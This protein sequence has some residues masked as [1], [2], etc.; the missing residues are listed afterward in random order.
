[1]VGKEFN[2]REIDGL[3]AATPPLEALRLLVSWAATISRDGVGVPVGTRR[4]GSTKSILIAD[5]SRE[6]F[7]APAN[8]DLC[9]GLP[10]EA[11]KDGETP[12]DVV[13]ELMASLYGARDASADWQEEM[14]R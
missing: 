3:F 12:E 6:F 7:E 2:D 1:M 10:A 9:V 8:R 11:L 4:K 14:N 5:V 13:G